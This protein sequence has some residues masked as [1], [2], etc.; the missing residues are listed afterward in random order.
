MTNMFN[1]L[2]N[3]LQQIENGS[4]VESVLKQ[5]PDFAN[6]LSSLLKTALKAQQNQ[7]AEPTAEVFRRSRAKVLQHA[8]TL[9]K[10]QPIKKN[11]TVSLFSRLAIS[12]T[13]AL[14][15][16][17]SGTG[18]LSASASSLPGERLYP[19]KRGWEN[20][21]LFLIFDQQARELLN[22]EFENE[23]LY[24]VNELLAQGRN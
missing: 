2:E 15:F 9:Q 23:R 21:R 13:L 10:P 11:R 18:L 24:E 1:V 8:A 5:Y 16:L 3:C 19:V 6:E 12:F 7:T 4:D 22:D 14:F 20:V 17:L